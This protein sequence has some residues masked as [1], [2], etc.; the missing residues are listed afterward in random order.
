MSK[1][2]ALNRDEIIKVDDFS[3]YALTVKKIEIMPVD[4]SSSGDVIVH[5][6]AVDKRSFFHRPTS[7]HH[8]MILMFYLRYSSND[9]Q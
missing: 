1:A 7:T 4:G 2:R 6:D 9:D 5:V 3:G 8:R